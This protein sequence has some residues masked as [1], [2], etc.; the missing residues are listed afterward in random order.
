MTRAREAGLV[1]GEMATGLHN[2]ITDVTGV[3]VGHTTLISGAGA[4]Q[5]GR[6]S[7]AHRR[8]GDSAA[9]RK[10]LSLEGGR[11]GAHDQ[12]LRQ[13]VRL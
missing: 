1:I 6:W 11:G 13:G 7:R 9:R 10:P 4:L 12:R 2:A 3:R 8:H 5:T